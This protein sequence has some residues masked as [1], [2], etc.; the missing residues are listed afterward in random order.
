MCKKLF[1]T[2][3]LCSI[4]GGQ[5]LFAA[6]DAKIQEACEAKKGNFIYADGECI[7]FYK[8]DGD[9]EGALNII[10]HGNWPEGT[11]TLG[12]Y[13]PFADSIAMATDTI[14]VAVALP[15]YSKSSS[16]KLKS[17]IKGA[18]DKPLAATK[19]YIKFLEELVVALKNKYDATT[20]TYIGH[21][22]GAMMGATLSGKNPDLI[23]NIAL[24]GGRYNVHEI[25]KDKTLISATDVINNMNKDMKMVLTYGGK[26]T[27]SPAK[28][29]T[30]FYNLAKS[31]GLKVKL[32]EV[33][34][35]EHVDLDMSDES[36]KAIV[37][38][39]EK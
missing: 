11:N 30:D 38:M 6:D 24:A 33:K 19:E 32:V 39:T 1:V 22:A 28:V 27:I 36:V 18:K 12:R 17:L 34:N 26:D 10:V 31:K 23:Q 25:S 2:V 13:A 35:G 7:E 9:K 4:L 8:A 16:N 14:T 29:T 15:G 37:N 3:G 20:V 5:F 21:S